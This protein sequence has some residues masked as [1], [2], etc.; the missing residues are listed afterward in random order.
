MVVLEFPRKPRATPELSHGRVVPIGI[1]SAGR[2]LTSFGFSPAAYDHLGPWL[3]A[4]MTAFLDKSDPDHPMGP[5][6]H[7]GIDLDVLYE[8][9]RALHQAAREIADCRYPKPR[10]GVHDDQRRSLRGRCVGLQAVIR[11]VPLAAASAP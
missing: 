2:H 10:H 8:R 11:N 9:S 3:T 5:L 6:G 7:Q 1:E 4:A